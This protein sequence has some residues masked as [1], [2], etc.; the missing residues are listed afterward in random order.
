MAKIVV[1]T[2]GSK[3]AAAAVQWAVTEAE[4]RHAD[5]EVVH[6]WMV[7]S[8][9]VDPTG[10]AMGTCEETGSILLKEAEAA[11]HEQSPGLS[12][13]TLLTPLTPAG[14]LVEASGDADLVVVGSRGHGGFTGLLLG[15]V[16]SQ[17]VHHSQCPVVVVRH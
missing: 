16:G 12:V 8:V 10:M 4:L 15:S 3:C 5:L 13:T 2:D 14:A 17:V 7:T 11:V 9:A 6:G 1:G